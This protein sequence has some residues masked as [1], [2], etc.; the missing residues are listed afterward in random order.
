MMPRF[1]LCKY[2]IEGFSEIGKWFN[3]TLPPATCITTF[4]NGALSYYSK[5]PTIDIL[6]LTDEHIARRG[7]RIKNGVPGHLLY[8]YCYLA[9]RKPSIVIFSEGQGFGADPSFNV[10]RPEFSDS[11]DP[12]SF[13][14]WAG[15]NP[16][17][18]YVN[19][20]VLCSE[21]DKIVRRLESMTGVEQ[22]KR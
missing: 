11:Y 22:V 9:L 14:F 8:D 10:F 2:Q 6:R 21:K 7:K 15:K 3:R 17:G 13:K 18:Q 16:L 4:A 20:L 12:V 1:N 5:C 19:F